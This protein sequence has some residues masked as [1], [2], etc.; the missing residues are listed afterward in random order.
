MLGV[1]CIV[2]RSLGDGDGCFESVMFD[3]YAFGKLNSS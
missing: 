3:G 1:A 2:N